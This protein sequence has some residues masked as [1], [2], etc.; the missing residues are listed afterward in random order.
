M[1]RRMSSWNQLTLEAAMLPSAHSSCRGP[2]RR[3]KR[4]MVV[5]TDAWGEWGIGKF[6]GTLFWGILDQRL[7]DPPAG[8]SA[9]I[10]VRTTVRKAFE[11]LSFSIVHPD[12]KK[13]FS[14]PLLCVIAQATVVGMV[15]SCLLN[16]HAMKRWGYGFPSRHSYLRN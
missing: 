14:R 13:N 5:R 1:D 3:V 4:P 2:S 15:A 10:C 8:V 12:T 6:N 7:T 11:T 16:T 9:A